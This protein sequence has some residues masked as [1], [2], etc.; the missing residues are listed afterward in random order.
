MMKAAAVSRC[1]SP[2]S[3]L[4]RLRDRDG[5]RQ[6]RRWA[7]RSTRATSRSFQTHRNWKIARAASAGTAQRQGQPEERRRRVGPVDRGR[8]EHRSR[9]AAH[10]VAQQVDRERQPEAGVGQPDREEG[11]RRCPRSRKSR[12]RGTS[13]TWSGTTSRP[14]TSTKRTSRPGKSI[15]A[16]A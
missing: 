2:P 8:L 4:T 7:P 15:H 3:E 13:V 12:S 1:H 5:Q 11:V 14:T 9:Q 6:V 16:K 10:V